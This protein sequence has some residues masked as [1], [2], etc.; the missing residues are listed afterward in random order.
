MCFN[1]IMIVWGSLKIWIGNIS[2]ILTLMVDAV[3]AEDHLPH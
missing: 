3:S 2:N 1:Q